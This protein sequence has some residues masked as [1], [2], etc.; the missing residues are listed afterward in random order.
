MPVSMFYNMRL[1]SHI[2]EMTGSYPL[3]G[4]RDVHMTLQNAWLQLS[5]HY[6]PCNLYPCAM[7]ALLLTTHC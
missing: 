6:D 2:G 1:N 3:M 7:N 5:A 4:L